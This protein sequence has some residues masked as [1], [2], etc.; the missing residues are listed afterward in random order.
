MPSPDRNCTHIVQKSPSSRTTLEIVLSPMRNAANARAAAP[1]S[2]RASISPWVVAWRRSRST[3]PMRSF[4]ER[5]RSAFTIHRV[6]AAPRARVWDIASDIGRVDVFHPLIERS[7]ATSKLSRGVGAERRCEFYGGKT[8]V[9]ERVTAWDEG[10]SFTI[11]AVKGMTAMTSAQATFAF[12][13]IGPATTNVRLTMRYEMKGGPFGSALGVLLTTPMMKRMLGRVL[14]GLDT[15]C[16]TG[17]PIGR[18]G[19]LLPAGDA[20]PH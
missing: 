3:T 2:G 9:D 6:I 12:E 15:H 19:V 14:A 18:N 20:R 16:Q 13:D 1:G 10:R 7:V 8:S 17:R 5:A 4:T 11:A